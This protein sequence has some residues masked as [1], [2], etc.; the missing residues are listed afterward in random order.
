MTSPAARAAFT[1]AQRQ[2]AVEVSTSPLDGLVIVDPG[3][4]ASDRVLVLIP[5][6]ITAAVQ[7]LIMYHAYAVIMTNS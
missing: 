3:H 2:R 5:P 7:T 4:S 1:T 6:T